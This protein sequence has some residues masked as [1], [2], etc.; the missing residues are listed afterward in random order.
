MSSPTPALS[1]LLTLLSTQAPASSIVSHHPLP[2]SAC[3]C[4]WLASTFVPW[5]AASSPGTSPGLQLSPSEQASHQLSC[6]PHTLAL[7]RKPALLP[8]LS[9]S[10]WGGGIST[11]FKVTLA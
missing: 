2:S 4:P 6:N 5:A 11:Q 8:G 7:L 9:A 10:Q 1:D 3:L